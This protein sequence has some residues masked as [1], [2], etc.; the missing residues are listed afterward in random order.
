[1]RLTQVSFT[2]IKGNDFRDFGK[3]P[4]NRGPLYYRFDCTVICMKLFTQAWTSFLCVNQL[5]KGKTNG[6]TVH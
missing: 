2:V 5:I 4:L 1:M 3:C 6:R